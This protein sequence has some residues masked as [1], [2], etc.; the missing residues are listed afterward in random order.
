M[1]FEGKTLQCLFD[2]KGERWDEES[3]GEK[4][5]TRVTGLNQPGNP[6]HELAINSRV[7]GH[8]PERMHAMKG[9]R[10][11]KSMT[12]ADKGLAHI[13]CIALI[14]PTSLKLATV[15]NFTKTLPVE[16]LRGI[17]IS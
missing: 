13:I 8:D 16:G 11:R 1:Y 3:G 5:V 17:G 6:R 10:G 4:A 15:R 12:Y 7:L 9:L 2:Y 14:Q